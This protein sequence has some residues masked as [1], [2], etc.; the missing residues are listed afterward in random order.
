MLII[1]N[2]LLKR[3]WLK[4]I[5]VLILGSII[6]LF[7]LLV[8]LFLLVLLLL[9]SGGCSLCF[10]ILNGF[11]FLRA[12]WN[13]VELLKLGLG[14]RLVS[15]RQS[16][17]DLEHLTSTFAIGGGDDWS[18]NVQEASVLEESM[19][20]EGKGISNPGYGTKS[21]SS[22]SQ[23]SILSQSLHHRS[24]LNWVRTVGVSK[25]LNKVVLD[26]INCKLEGLTW[27]GRFDE[28]SLNHNRGTSI[29]LSSQ[30]VSLNLTLG[31]DL[32]TL[33]A[34]A[35]VQLD[36]SKLF[37]IHS[38]FLGP[39]GNSNSFTNE[40]FVTLPKSGDANTLTI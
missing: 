9:F 30:G 17:S 10:L 4:V 40:F 33:E 15:F 24:T 31:N 11:D 13:L 23:M 28:S 25:A 7:L 29:S 1:N 27:L 37:L 12:L 32:Q 8:F 5:Q 18:V 14:N 36:E 34:A 22:S 39:A 20:G 19:S 21:V 2:L 6:I 26:V 16:S 38:A 35:I 3:N